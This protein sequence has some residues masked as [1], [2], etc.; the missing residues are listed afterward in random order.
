MS[1]YQIGSTLDRPDGT[2]RIVRVITHDVTLFE[3][4]TGVYTITESYLQLKSTDG[5]VDHFVLESEKVP[6]TG[7]ASLIKGLNPLSWRPLHA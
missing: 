1:E 3:D 6:Y 4:A 5:R 2:W 7:P